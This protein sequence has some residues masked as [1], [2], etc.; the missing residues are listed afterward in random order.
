GEHV[1]DDKI[2]MFNAGA[3]VPTAK[4]LT[5]YHRSYHLPSLY[6]PSGMRTWASLVSDW[7]ECWDV[8]NNIPRDMLLLQQ[9]YNNVLAEAFEIQGE[10][11]RF[12]RVAMHRRMFYRSG[13]IPNERAIRCSNSPIHLVTMA[14][15]VHK[16]HMD[17]QVVGWCKH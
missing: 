17:I 2:S 4:P 10:A 11:L 6:S 16:K 1:N 8:V 7:L 14:V 15:D 5:P 9:F 12:E 3:W 13:Q